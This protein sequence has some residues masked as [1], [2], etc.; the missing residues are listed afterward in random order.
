MFLSFVESVYWNLLTEYITQISSPLFHLPSLQNDYNYDVSKTH[1][2]IFHLLNHSRVFFTSKMNRSVLFSKEKVFKE[3]ILVGNKQK[4]VYPWE[5]Q[6]CLSTSI[7][8][9]DRKISSK[10][11]RT[12][13][14]TSQKIFVGRR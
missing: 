7:L 6:L 8:Y 10:I 11:A 4:Y 14:R 13:A 3:I 9:Q 5:K 12:T 1:C 2:K